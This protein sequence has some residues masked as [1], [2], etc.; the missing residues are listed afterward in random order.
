MRAHVYVYILRACLYM[1]GWLCAFFICV[2]L[3]ITIDLRYQDEC[4]SHVALPQH[5]SH[6][7]GEG[8]LSNLNIQDAGLRLE[9]ETQDLCE[10]SLGPKSII[11]ACSHHLHPS[12]LSRQLKCCNSFLSALSHNIHRGKK[13][14]DTVQVLS[15][16]PAQ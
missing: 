16:I 7:A 12:L 11:S 13:K 10:I 9:S 2:L 4:G 1:F 8:F 6:T 14:K 5:C 15:L 3:F